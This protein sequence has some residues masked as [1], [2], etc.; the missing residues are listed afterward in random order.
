MALRGS[1][2]R[3]RHCG[4]H[5][6]CWR[7]VVWLQLNNYP[8][9]TEIAYA[10]VERLRNVGLGGKGMAVLIGAGVAGSVAVALVAQHEMNNFKNNQP[11]MPTLP[12]VR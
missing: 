3:H 12:G 4:A 1:E 2:E 9:T 5:R 8:E 11:P 6:V 10:D 7:A